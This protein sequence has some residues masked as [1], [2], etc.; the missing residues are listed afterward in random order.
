[1]QFFALTVAFSIDTYSSVWLLLKRQGLQQVSA[2]IA[3]RVTLRAVFFLWTSDNQAGGEIRETR[4]PRRLRRYSQTTAIDKGISRVCSKVMRPHH[5]RP[6]N[7]V[8]G[9]NQVSVFGTIPLDQKSDFAVPTVIVRAIQDYSVERRVRQ[10][11]T[12]YPKT[13]NNTQASR[14]AEF[15]D[16]Q[17]AYQLPV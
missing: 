11:Q 3:T 15:T 12:L 8:S 17:Y 10:R 6:A 1:M 9:A 5:Q 2:G 14:L 7:G 4:T 13:H 16:S